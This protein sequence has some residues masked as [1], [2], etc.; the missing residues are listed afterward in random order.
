VSEP[1]PS[2]IPLVAKTL[3]ALAA[4]FLL[5]PVVGLVVKAP[6]SRAGSALSGSGAWTA[7][8]LS[9]IVS[10]CAA[11]LAMLFGVPLAWVLARAHFRG[12]SVV[13][14]IA[15]LPIV[16]PP[17]VG[18]IGLLAALGR[19]GFVGSLLHRVGIQLTFT[20]A[21]AVL[22]STFVSMPLVILA[23][24]AGLRSLD[25]RFEMAAAAMGSS[26]ARTFTRVTLPMLKSQLVAGLVLAWA[27]ALGEFGATITFAGNL[28][29]RTQTLPLAAYQA[30]QTDPGAAIVTSLLLVAVSLAVLIGLRGRLLR[31]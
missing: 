11:V 29:G 15:V 30:L 21:G 2:R 13:R 3:A 16:L 7:L 5:L 20:T 28:P 22:A 6:W 1:S 17:V 10:L 9:A 26:P 12:R 19:S 23:T 31:A 27:R 4:V 18:G 24:E 14:S 25:P 8:R